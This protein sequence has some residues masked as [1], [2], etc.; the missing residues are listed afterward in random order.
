M[1]QFLAYAGIAGLVVSIA[2]GIIGAVMAIRPWPA[3]VARCHAQ[4]E[5]PGFVWS[6]RY[7]DSIADEKKRKSVKRGIVLHGIGLAGLILFFPFVL[8]SGIAS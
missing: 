2:I 4:G 3:Y 6:N 8:L 5:Q 7:F 1:V